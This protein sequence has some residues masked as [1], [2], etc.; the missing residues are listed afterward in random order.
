MENALPIKNRT[1]LRNWY[2]ANAK[3]EKEL[4]VEVIRKKPK[5]DD[6]LYYLDAV[7]EAICFG[8]IDSVFK[9]VNGKN[10]QRFSPRKKIVLGRCLISKE[11]KD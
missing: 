4:W 2:L 3:K 11:R 5:E 8:W 10:Y 1:E 6:R 9:E 7:E